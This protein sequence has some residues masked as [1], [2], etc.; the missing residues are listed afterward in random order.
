MKVKNYL[1]S[2]IYVF[3]IPVLK[4]SIAAFFLVSCAIFI[5]S[6]HLIF[7]SFHQRL[8]DS[9]EAEGVRLASHLVSAFINSSDELKT[10]ITDSF[11]LKMKQAQIDFKLEKIK[12]FNIDG[13]VL[14]STYKADIGKVNK[15]E[16]FKDI[17]KNGGVFSKIINEYQ[18]P[19]NNFEKRISAAEIYVPINISGKLIGVFEIYFDVTSQNL[20]VKKNEKFFKIIASITWIILSVIFLILIIRAVKVYSNLAQAEEE[21]KKTNEGLENQI[22]AKT[23]E[24]RM[25]Q[26]I[27]VSA[28]AS[29]AEYYDSD[30]G[31]HLERMEKYVRI[32]LSELRD[33]DKISSQLTEDIA[34]ASLLHDAGKTAVPAEILTKPSRLNEE[35][36]EKVKFHTVAA[37][38]SF[39]KANEEFRN[40]FGKDSYLALA[41]DIAQHH[42]EKWNGTGYPKGLQ[43][44]NIPFSARLVAIVDVYDALTSK[45]PYKEPWSHEEAY[46]TIIEESG[47]H[48][49]P[50]LV[51]IFIQCSD[52]FRVI[53]KQ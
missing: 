5:L 45:R 35:E 9:I 24:I 53:S 42:H 49:D 33:E 30:T 43:G 23:L 15:R 14:Y 2:C 3:K 1:Q 32:L 39:E 6:Q 50:E 12:I 19:L 47:K 31:H 36:F 8:K 4:L 18:S 7:P 51:E 28:L 11:A 52:Q 26:R 21:L 38:A 40:L 22:L 48:F 17:V 37:G 46:L 16:Y 29:L 41:R 27:S 25:T 34:L 13:N 20:A 10:Q 44:A